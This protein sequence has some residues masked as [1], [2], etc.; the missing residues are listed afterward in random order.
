MN[1]RTICLACDGPCVDCEGTGECWDCEGD[2]CT[3]C[4]YDGTCPCCD[5]Q[6]S[7][8]DRGR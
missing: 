8:E 7:G 4:D 5:G 3:A 1:R 2:G 6:A